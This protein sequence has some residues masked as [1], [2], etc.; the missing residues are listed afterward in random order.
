MIEL[1]PFNKQ[2]LKII[3]AIGFKED[4]PEWSKWNSPYFD[5]YRSYQTFEEFKQSKVFDYLMSDTCRG[6]YIDSK[7][8]GMVSRYWENKMTRWLEIGIIIYQSNGWSKG[9]GSMALTQWVTQTFTDFPEVQRVGLTTW[10]GNQRMMRAAKKIGMTQEACIRK[11]RYFEG[12]YYDSVKYGVL[13]D[14]WDLKEW[15]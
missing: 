4:Y 13:R 6:I 11:V 15:L 12:I 8:I 7:P 14:E 10:S 9:I 5:E 1:K 3:W 2:D